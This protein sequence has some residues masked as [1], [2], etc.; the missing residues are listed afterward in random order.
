MAAKQL[1]ELDD[2]S[3]CDLAML[4]PVAKLLLYLYFLSAENH[5][6]VETCYIICKKA[7]IASKVIMDYIS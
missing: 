7:M 6:Q 2:S 1:M 4:L 5:K 3:R